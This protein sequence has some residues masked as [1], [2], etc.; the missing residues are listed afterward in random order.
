MT[1]F[2][3]GTGGVSFSDLLKDGSKHF[4]G[5][6]EATMRNI[7]ACKKLSEITR[8]SLGPNGMNKLIKNHLEK[9][10]VTN[11]AATIIKEMEVA[12]PA[13]KLVALAASRQ[14]TEQGDATNLV[15]ILAG[16]LLAQA[17]SL[18]TMGL[19]TADIIDGYVLASKDTIELMD[20]L[21]ISS[22]QDI[23][24][25]T[26]VASFLKPVLAAHQYGLED[27]LSTLVAKACTDVCPR[28]PK[29][30]SVDNVRITK[31]L[32]ST[33]QASTVVNGFVFPRDSE[34]T[35]K[36]IEGGAKIAVFNCGI[37][38]S[39]TETKGTVL[40]KSA[41]EL[42][43]YSLSE[44]AAI[45]KMIKE[46][47]D[48]GVNVVVSNG[49]ISEMSQHFL[50]RYGIMVIKCPSKFE[51]RRICKSIG[52]TG[53]ARVGA[54]TPEE[55]GNCDHVN[56]IEIGGSKC[57]VFRQDGDSSKVASI[58]LRS[59]THNILDDLER[60]IEDAVNVYKMSC[61][62]PRFVA[63]AGAC[64]IEIARKMSE[65]A[66]ANSGLAQYS[67]RKFGESLEVVPRTLAENAG[68]NATEV[69]ASLYATHA[70]GNV[71]D[72]VDIESTGT[73]QVDAAA[74]GI[75]DHLVCKREAIRLAVNAAVTVL[76]V[77]QIIM[78][79]QAGGPKPPGQ[80]GPGM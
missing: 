12:H 35:I 38:A 41:K 63:G 9:L 73:R 22:I 7:E 6:D 27:C 13:A 10:F 52:A 71:N 69:I 24:N 51:T 25:P 39:G 43:E 70:M 31:I 56:V 16:E 50:E 72:G 34:G 28:D 79:K 8:T 55:M 46:I 33:L 65:K 54:P 4:S 48:S 74:A 49:A 20:S 68:Q 18:L 21:G 14:E 77:D 2:M 66:D 59:S 29:F 1:S 76:R 42:E 78:A 53:L 44:E 15:V 37:E 57:C 11:D 40:L 64:E 58:V 75:I 23:R 3:S 47:S 62:D 32:G 36:K 5:V 61:T 60:A 17:E 45:E 80:M 67:I 19:H 30:F 26:E